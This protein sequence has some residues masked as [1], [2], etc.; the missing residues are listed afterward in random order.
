MNTAV[1]KDAET[2]KKWQHWQ[3]MPKVYKVSGR[4]CLNKDGRW[5]NSPLSLK[6]GTV[7]LVELC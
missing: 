3:R 5:R 2:V 6:P 7:L 1:V 4:P